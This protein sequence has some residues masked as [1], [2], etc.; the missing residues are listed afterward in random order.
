MAVTH[1]C[2][3]LFE[4]T[5]MVACCVSLY[6]HS[7]IPRRRHPGWFTKPITALSHQNSPTR[8]VERTSLN[9]TNTIGIQPSTQATGTQLP[10]ARK[11]ATR[12]SFRTGG[13][14]EKHGF[15]FVAVLGS[16]T[17]LERAP[18]S[19]FGMKII[20]AESLSSAPK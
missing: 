11:F 13:S 15:V 10:S 9:L 6:P 8:L 5:V 4:F 16:T 12:S 3:S 2:V 20:R 18:G 14:V 7:T 17:P 19:L 1:V